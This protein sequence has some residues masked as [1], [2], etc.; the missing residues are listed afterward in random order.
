[1][2]GAVAVL[3]AVA[4]ISAE[5]AVPRSKGKADRAIAYASF[6]KGDYKGALAALERALQLIIAS[7]I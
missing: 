1:M 3:L 2:A 5:S 4:A 6:G 7:A